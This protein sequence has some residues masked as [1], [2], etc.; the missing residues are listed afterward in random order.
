MV[1]LIVS[2]SPVRGLANGRN[3]LDLGRLVVTRAVI[4]S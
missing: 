4:S 3:S 1:D 2:P